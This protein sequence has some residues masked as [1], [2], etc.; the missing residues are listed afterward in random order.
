MR[1]VLRS[2]KRQATRRGAER[3]TVLLPQV[4]DYANDWA[5][6]WRQMAE[7]EA[8]QGGW[9]FWDLTL[10]LRDLAPLDAARLFRDLDGHYTPEGNRWVAAQ[11]LANRE[12]GGRARD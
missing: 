6:T 9:E 5:D 1:R 12:R 3:V 10:P 11:L 2:T 4:E 8:E 7:E